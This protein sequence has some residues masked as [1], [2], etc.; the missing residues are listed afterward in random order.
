MPSHNITTHEPD[1]NMFGLSYT[2]SLQFLDLP[3]RATVFF[4]SFW[5]FLIAAPLS[6]DFNCIP[7][8]SG[9][10]QFISLCPY[11]GPDASTFFKSPPNTSF[12]SFIH[13]PSPFV[14]APPIS[15]GFPVF[16]SINSPFGPNSY[17]DAFASCQSACA[18]KS[19]YILASWVAVCRWTSSSSGYSV[20]CGVISIH[21]SGI[22][23]KPF[24]GLTLFDFFLSLAAIVISLSLQFIVPGKI[25]LGC[26]K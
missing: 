21:Q 16:L 1:M 12:P 15:I 2:I 26:S 9:F 8:H 3:H 24:G 20:S 6:L 23:A 19:L 11:A 14:N 7:I 4:S 10:F 22:W 13:P 18:A 5:P 25:F 17:F